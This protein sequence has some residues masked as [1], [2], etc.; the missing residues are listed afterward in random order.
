MVDRDVWA[1]CCAPFVAS[2]HEVVRRMLQVAGVGP[3]DVVYD[4]GSGDGRILFTA[5]K[6]FG[7]RKAVGYEIRKD[8]IERCLEQVRI[9]N[10]QDRIKVYRADLFKAD[11]SEATVITLYLTSS[12]NQRLRPK[13][14]RE[15][16]NGTRI[17]SHDFDIYGWRPV[18]K[19]NFKGHTIYLYVVRRR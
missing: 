9:Q 3:D 5:V 12:A 6:E 8:L 10:L 1:S 7:A 2:D 16:R 18:L 17:V 13:F 19:E 15:A 11:I 14:E 4:L